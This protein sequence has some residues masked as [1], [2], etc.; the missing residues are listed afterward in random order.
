MTN[1]FYIY[2]VEDKNN[3]DILD[4]RATREEARQSLRQVKKEGLDARIIQE[5]Y[6]L[7]KRQQ[8]R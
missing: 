7:A 5:Q 3:G 4:E 6:V 1:A 2:R 8:V